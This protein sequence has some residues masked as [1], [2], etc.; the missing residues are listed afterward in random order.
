MSFYLIVNQAFTKIAKLKQV[1]IKNDLAIQQYDFTDIDKTLFLFTANSSETAHYLKLDNGDCICTVGTFM[2]KGYYGNQALQSAYQDISAQQF[3]HQECIGHY[4]IIIKIQQ[5]IHLYTDLLGAW[6]IYQSAQGEISSSF[7]LLL[8]LQDKLSLNIQ[9]VYEYILNGCTLGEKTI[10]QEI[11]SLPAEQTYIIDQHG[12]ITRTDVSHSLLNQENNQQ[13]NM[14]ELLDDYSERLK[15]VFTQ[16]Q[17]LPNSQFR[18]ALSGGFD[19][20]LILASFLKTGTQPKLYVYGKETDADVVVAKNVAEVAGLNLDFIDKSKLPN[21]LEQQSFADIM[22]RNLFIYDGLSYDGIVDNGNDYYDRLNR[23]ANDK[24]LVN[25][26]VGEIFRHFYYLSNCNI[27]ID[28]FIKSFHCRYD[29]QKMGDQFNEDEYRQGIKQEIQKTLKTEQTLLSREQV[30]KLY[31][32][33]R[34]RYWSAKDMTN[35]HRFGLALYPFMEYQLIQGT[36]TISFNKKLY[37]RFEAQLINSLAPELAACNSDYGFA[38]NTEPPAKYKLKTQLLT[39]QRPV[40]LRKNM[41][42]FKNKRQTAN[43]PEYLTDKYLKD[44]INAQYPYMTQYFKQISTLD[45]ETLNRLVTIEYI[46]EKYNF[47]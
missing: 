32:L 31:P 36:S 41:Y 24:I 9:G 14:E 44:V 3:K 30:E 37:G 6:K 12:N 23:S 33:L 21:Q 15:N 17:Q 16:Y 11:N 10:A 1:A 42:A 45:N 28:D 7:Y 19:S 22:E 2:Y 20:R 47:S 43:P 27:S 4:N 26:S 38:F 46:A 35:N 13:K 39:Y 8:E 18:S 5:K 29:H 34:A 40:W 25:G